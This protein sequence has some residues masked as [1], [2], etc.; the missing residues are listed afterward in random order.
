MQTRRHMRRAAGIP[1][2]PATCVPDGLAVVPFVQVTASDF[3]GKNMSD[4]V[5]LAS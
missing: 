4:L 1:Q 3:A 2:N 5:A